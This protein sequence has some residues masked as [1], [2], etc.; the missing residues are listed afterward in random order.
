MLSNYVIRRFAEP[1]DLAD[2]VPFQASDAGAWS[3]GRT[4]PLDG[5]HASAVRGP[6]DPIHQASEGR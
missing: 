4:Y 6:G 5:G 2:M 1:Q 3:T